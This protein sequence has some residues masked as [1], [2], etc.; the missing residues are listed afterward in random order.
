MTIVEANAYITDYYLAESHSEDDKFLFVEALHVLIE[1]NHDPNDMHNLACFYAEEREFDLQLKYLEMAADMNFFVS[2]ESL[3]YHWYY[4]QSGIVDYEKAFYYFSK[5]AQSRDDYLRIGC[6]YKIADMYRYG[7]Y[8]EKDEQKY[9]DMIER[10]YDEISHPDRLCTIIPMEFISEP[11]LNV[12]V[13]EIRLEQGRHEEAVILLKQ[14]RLQFAEY[15]RKNPSWWGNIEEMETVVMMLHENS[16]DW[17][18]NI[19]LYDLFWIAGEERSLTF[20]YKNIRF[21]AE[22]MTEEG[23]VVIRFNN[24]WYGDIQ[25]FYEKAKIGGRPVTA[26]YDDLSGYEIA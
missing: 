25:D 11:S 17:E 24:Q 1:A 23:R 22:C 4:G 20:R 18:E 3:G 16:I 10:L 15:I 19:D 7:Y 2:Y 8:V 26:L 5:G 21:K 9:R 14:A 13:A 12:R 6:E